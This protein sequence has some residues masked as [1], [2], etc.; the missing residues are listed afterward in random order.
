MR[1]SAQRVFTDPSLRP[2]LKHILLA[3]INDLPSLFSVCCNLRDYMHND[4]FFLSVCENM[5]F[6]VPLFRYSLDGDLPNRPL[7]I[8]PLACIESSR[9]EE[10]LQVGAP[11]LTRCVHPEGEVLDVR[12]GY[13]ATRTKAG[14]GWTLWALPLAHE[15]RRTY[16]KN[17]D[18]VKLSSPADDMI[19]LQDIY[20]PPR[21]KGA[22]DQQRM[23]TWEFEWSDKFAALAIYP[24]DNIVIIAAQPAFVPYASKRN[25]PLETGRAHR[26]YFFQLRPFG[27]DR[28]KNK[29]KAVSPTPL[30]QHPEAKLP[31][32]EFIMPY[33]MGEW[34]VSYTLKPGPGG[35][36]GLLIKSEGSRSCTTGP[37]IVFNWIHGHCVTAFGIEPSLTRT[38][39]FDFFS[40]KHIV[41]LN[42]RP[43]SDEEHDTY[44]HRPEGAPKT[45]PDIAVL[46]PSLVLV[47]ISPNLGHA[48][49]VSQLQRPIGGQG[50]SVTLAHPPGTWTVCESFATSSNG[51]VALELP[52][53]SDNM[54]T[55]DQAGEVL[56]TVSGTVCINPPLSLGYLGSMV[57]YA[58]Y[59]HGGGPS[60]PQ[61]RPALRGRINASLFIDRVPMS[62][63]RMAVES[64]LRQWREQL[65]QSKPDGTEGISKAFDDLLCLMVKTHQNSFKESR[66]NGETWRLDFYHEIEFRYPLK[67]FTSI[68]NFCKSLEDKGFF[69]NRKGHGGDRPFTRLLDAIENCGGMQVQAKKFAQL[70]CPPV[71]PLKDIVP[72]L[73]GD[74]QSFA[75]M[76]STWMIATATYGPRAIDIESFNI[77]SHPPPMAIRSEDM[78]SKKIRH[79]NFLVK[80]YAGGLYFPRFHLL[81]GPEFEPLRRKCAPECKVHHTPMLVIPTGNRRVGCSRGSTRGL[82]TSNACPDT[83]TFSP[84]VITTPYPIARNSASL[85][86]PD[87]MVTRPQALPYCEGQSV[88]V[89]DQASIKEAYFDGQSFVLVQKDLVSIFC[90]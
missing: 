77:Y 39:D 27:L 38:I 40:A 78:R 63:R 72:D 13:M 3:S 32:L 48:L 6:S 50:A 42:V 76:Q 16:L 61:P 43:L 53:I 51:I 79:S 34:D 88:L 59:P 73:Q 15:V 21:P 67:L 1:T 65:D 4:P 64:A 86:I 87:L 52:P 47:R 82:P 8:R 84:N 31:F 70:L 41:L 49:N 74:W 68:I 83:P 10:S 30:E 19:P 75:D 17:Q 22:V 89:C 26:I 33:H 7:D 37:L 55:R 2:V 35:L 69:S 90:F 46:S 66:A 57:S 12:D 71:R 56:N 25:T 81:S 24:Q 28:V 62:T 58:L 23:W 45:S 60:S 85:P 14:T 18:D 5:T 29:P 44:V 54:T 9:R 80:S 20:L 11:V 36:V